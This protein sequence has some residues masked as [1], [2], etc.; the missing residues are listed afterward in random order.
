MVIVC[1]DRIDFCCVGG[2]EKINERGNGGEIELSWLR[3][4]RTSER[5]KY[6]ELFTALPHLVVTCPLNFALFL[7]LLFLPIFF[8]LPLS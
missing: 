1:T 4:K 3:E 8:Y 2:G 6:F 7:S 5:M